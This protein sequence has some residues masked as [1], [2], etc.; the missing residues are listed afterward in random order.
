MF[1]D[2]IA[3]AIRQKLSDTNYGEI[4]AA[5]GI[6]TAALDDNGDIVEYRADAS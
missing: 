5:R 4:L 1:N 3:A 6:T 2:E